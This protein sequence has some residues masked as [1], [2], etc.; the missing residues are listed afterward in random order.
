[1]SGGVL[2]SMYGGGGHVP[3]IWHKCAGNLR[4]AFVQ[5]QVSLILL[6]PAMLMLVKSF[7][8]MEDLYT[9]MSSLALSDGVCSTLCLSLANL[10]SL[11]PFLLCWNQ[12]PFVHSRV[13]FGSSV[14][15]HVQGQ[16]QS[17]CSIQSPRGWRRNMFASEKGV[18]SCA[19]CPTTI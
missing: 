17:S 10:L 1:M 12:L 13:V 19:I 6:G 16:M 18:R 5:G 11:L 8:S 3:M 4:Y 9:S 14:K 7:L 15:Y 2:L